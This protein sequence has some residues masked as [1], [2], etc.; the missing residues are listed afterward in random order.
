MNNKSR[1]LNALIKELEE[2]WGYSQ[3]ELL[4]IREKIKDFTFACLMDSDVR[5]DLISEKDE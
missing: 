1:E 4:D 5:K 2:T 3:E